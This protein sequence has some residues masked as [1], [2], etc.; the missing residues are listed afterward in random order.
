MTA[1][2][3]IRF[4]FDYISSNAYLAW[5]ELPKLAARHGAVIEPVPVLFA[6][7]LEA[8]GQLGPAEIRNKALWMLK[9]NLRKAALLGVPLNP[10][11]HHPFNP[12]LSLRASGVPKNAA[13]RD[14]LVTGLFEAV[15]VNG[16]HVSEPA[17]VERVAAAAGLDGAKLVAQ[18][19]TPES[20]AR[21]RDATEDAV[22]NGVFGVPTMRVGDELF[23]GYDDFP[24]LELLL[25]G[26][27][28]L[29]VREREKWQR[30]EPIP[31]S[32]R[33]QVRQRGGDA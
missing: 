26:K 32:V 22:A 13:K 3:T 12:L 23:W 19:Q 30:S 28:P 20:K 5:L 14:A 7:L 16:Q 18:A 24:Y 29:E 33:R 10:P 6:A 1:P 2:Q 21:L 11:A 4:F 9:N 15:W 8:H 31:S 17:V 25:A 27:D